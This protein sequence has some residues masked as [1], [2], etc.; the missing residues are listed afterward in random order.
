MNLREFI[1][2]YAEWLWNST[3]KMREEK[4]LAAFKLNLDR[5]RCEDYLN[6]RRYCGGYEF[7][8][9]S[10]N[11]CN[12][13]IPF[14][15]IRRHETSEYMSIDMSISATKLFLIELLKNCG[16]MP[17]EEVELIENEDKVIGL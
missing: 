7:S 5:Q 9:A 13:C 17:I 3:R 6:G 12:C 14:I 16:T 2:A 10:S 11:Q 8:F 4:I 15:S 1:N